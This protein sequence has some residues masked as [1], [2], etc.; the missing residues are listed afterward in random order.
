MT[1]LRTYMMFGAVPAELTEKA[2]AKFS[3]YEEEC[4]RIGRPYAVPPQ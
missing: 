4:K 3:A 1:R 2:R